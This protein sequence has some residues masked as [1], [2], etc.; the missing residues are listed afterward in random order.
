M[1]QIVKRLKQDIMRQFIHFTLIIAS[2]FICSCSNSSEVNDNQII[3]VIADDGHNYKCPDSN[4]PHA[5]DLG[6]PSGTLWACCNVG[7]T[8][9]EEFGGY[10][11][12]GEIETKD[13]YDWNSYIHCDGTRE[14]CHDLGHDIA[15]TQYDVAHVKWGGKWRMPSYEEV[16]ELKKN[17]MPVFTIEKEVKG[18]IIKNRYGGHIF[19][20]VCDYK[21]AFDTGSIGE[22]H[23][24]ISTTS[25]N[26]GE[27]SD[28]LF[29]DTDNFY[30]KN[31]LR[32]F[33]LSIRPVCK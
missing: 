21:H 25:N 20:P 28:Y 7:A 10:Y 5:I 29:F 31:C 16:M 27:L 30:T 1:V 14:T 23:Y 24:W 8:K 15:G 9:P 6:L 12:W 18:I 11:A 33:G 4:H 3:D 17:T 2:L 19:I 13:V 32:Y 22:G 26:S